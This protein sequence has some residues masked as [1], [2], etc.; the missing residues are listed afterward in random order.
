MNIAILTQMLR[1]NYGGLLQNWA[2]QQML[3]AMGHTPVTVDYGIIGGA[4]RRRM[5]HKHYTSMLS[6]HYHKTRHPLPSW[7]EHPYALTRRFVKTRID[8]TAP[9][10]EITPDFWEQQAF[11]AYI[12]GSDQ[13]WR[14]LY[15][16]PQALEAM[17]LA[18]LKSEA[19]LLIAYAAS[20]GIDD[21]EFTPEQTL[22]ARDNL[23][24]FHAVSVREASG[25]G[26]C[27]E[28]LDFPA[29]VHV[30]DPTMMIDRDRYASL[31]SKSDLKAIPDDCMAIYI[32]DDDAAK[33]DTVDKLLSDTGLRPMRLGI[34][35]NGQQ[36]PV[37]QWLA[38]LLKARYIV[39]DSFHGVA[40][41]INFNI[42]FTIIDNPDRGSARVD[43]LLKLFGLESRC[44]PAAANHPV[45]WSAVN[46]RKEELRRKSSDF[47]QN[48]L[49]L[50]PA[51]R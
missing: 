35:I 41:A 2:L 42:P 19:P 14:P 16:S 46:F 50:R 40:F 9:M 25:V 26:L 43:S 45:D 51:P 49:S 47:L 38:T 27:R 28:R 37:E 10:L 33:R 29:A 22:M 11:D 23:R 18:P 44:N 31:I 12:V 20:F 36:P 24:K 1:D 17:F 30:L 13:T 8:T 39:T 32:L 7:I 48:S 3:K 5:I 6:L 15:N 21:W 34:K 4:L